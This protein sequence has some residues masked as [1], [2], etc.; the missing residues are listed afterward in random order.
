MDRQDATILASYDA[1]Q[2]KVIQEQKS[3][4]ITL[5]GLPC[6]Y[7]SFCQWRLSPLNMISLAKDQEKICTKG[8]GTRLVR[9]IQAPKL[10]DD[11]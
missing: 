7:R 11:A 5:T 4:P 1:G 3:S 2:P 10:I 6:Y 9:D 8:F